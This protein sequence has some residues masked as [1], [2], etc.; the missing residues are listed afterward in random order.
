MPWLRFYVAVA[1]V[2]GAADVAVVDVAVVDVA[3]ADVVAVAGTDMVTDTS[4]A[5]KAE[6]ARDRLVARGWA[7]SCCVACH[8]S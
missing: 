4:T 6:T 2:A 5:L 7:T 8:P 3:V 1:G